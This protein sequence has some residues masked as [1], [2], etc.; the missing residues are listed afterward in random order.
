MPDSES[1]RG[2]DFP[3]LISIEDGHM[4]ERRL[5]V[6]QGLLEKLIILSQDV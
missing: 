2:G 4:L 3:G 5:D 6:L 1:R